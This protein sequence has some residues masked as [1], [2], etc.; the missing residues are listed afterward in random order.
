MC[1]RNTHPGDTIRD[2]GQTALSGPVR[3]ESRT[4]RALRWLSKRF[5]SAPDR[6]G[7]RLGL[8]AAGGLPGNSQA[9]KKVPTRGGWVSQGLWGRL[10][11]S[12]RWLQLKLP[13]RACTHT[14]THINIL[15]TQAH[16]LFIH[17]PA[18]PLGEK[19]KR[20]NKLCSFNFFF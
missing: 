2:Q 18:Q 9:L 15:H 4:S 13:E 17:Q 12:A 19:H 14:I 11:A 20:A 5:A 1:R 6:T 16:S 3:G 8:G 7:T 10:A